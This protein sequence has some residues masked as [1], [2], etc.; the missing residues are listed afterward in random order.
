MVRENGGLVVVV[1]AYDWNDEVTPRGSWLGGHLDDDG[2]KV[3][4][5]RSWEPH[6][7]LLQQD[8]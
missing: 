6:L 7:Q 1:S 5:D 3:S 2:N 4:A 8:L